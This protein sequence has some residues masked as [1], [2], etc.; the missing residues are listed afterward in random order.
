MT[1]DFSSDAIYDRKAPVAVPQSL[2]FTPNAAQ[3]KKNVADYVRR[4]AK[5]D[6]AYAPKLADE[7]ADGQVFQQYGQMLGSVGLDPNNLADHFAAW[8]ITAW[9]A[10]QIGPVETPASAAPSVKMQVNRMLA[11]QSFGAMTSAQKQTFADSL[12]IQALILTK[13]IDQVKADPDGARQLSA[14]IKSGAAKF[15]LDLGSMTLTGDGFVPIRKKR[16]D[17]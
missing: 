12:A 5:I 17:A 2:R 7:L 14:G 8:W 13:Q 10:S 15:G 3:R 4:V 6:K 1:E 16:C 9:E 11:D